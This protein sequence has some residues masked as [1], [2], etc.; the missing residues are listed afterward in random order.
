[1]YKAVSRKNCWLLML[2]L[3]LCIFWSSFRKDGALVRVFDYQS[4]GSKFKYFW[5][6]QCLTHSFI[7]LRSIKW[8]LGF[9]GNW[10]KAII[11]FCDLSFMGHK[12][13]FI[14][15]LS[16]IRLALLSTVL[17]RCSDWCRIAIKDTDPNHF[18]RN[19]TLPLTQL[20]KIFK[21]YFSL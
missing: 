17:N 19:F 7:P 3:M 15:S 14:C 8:S 5:M 1:M 2:W 12:V 9:L 4:R 6:S 13:P 11:L 10:L 21:V 20:C 16:K 18:I